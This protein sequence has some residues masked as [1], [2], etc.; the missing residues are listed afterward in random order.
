MRQNMGIGKA[1]IFDMD[2]VLMANN[3]WHIDAWIEFA[4]RYG[5]QMT[6]E[7]VESAFG[8]TNRDYLSKLF[9]RSISGTEAE[10]L[11]EE[12]ETIY[13]RNFQPIMKPLEG[14]LDFLYELKNAGFGIGLATG[15]PLS[16][17]NFVLDQ[18]QIRDFFDALV[19]DAMVAKGKPDPQGYLLASELLKIEP[20][21]CLVFE[22]SSNGV[23]AA[24]R[25]GMRVVGVN[26]SGKPHLLANTDM[27]IND[28][29]GITAGQVL[30]ILNHQS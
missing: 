21:C 26:T 10:I 3:P 14:L 1:V 19:Y 9:G 4:S 5:K 13:R 11:S 7:D 27:I 6:R 2:G 29:T 16:N 22:D 20:T 15:G 30:S 25:A 23:L 8:N 28:F 17:V 18:I 12:K 24:Q